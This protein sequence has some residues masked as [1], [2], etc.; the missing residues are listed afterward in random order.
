MLTMTE[1]SPLDAD[2]DPLLVQPP[3]GPAKGLSSGIIALVLICQLALPLRYYLGP[4]Q[5]DE[6]FAWR[7]FSSDFMSHKR[8]KNM[9]LEQVVEGEHLT[10]RRVPIKSLVPR[11]WFHPL[12]R[13]QRPIVDKLLRWRCDQGGVLGIRY[14]RTCPAI[15]GGEPQSVG[16]EISC[17]THQ[18]KLIEG[19]PR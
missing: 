11:I 6:R 1:P 13:F 2:T 10:V 19:S 17:P 8:C 18:I 16:L 9:M 14:G 7:M 12:G 15:D 5:T 4:D 3:S